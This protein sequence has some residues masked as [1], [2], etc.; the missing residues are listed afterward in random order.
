MLLRELKLY[1]PAFVVLLAPQIGYAKDIIFIEGLSQRTAEK[2]IKM[3]IEEFEA[4]APASQI[5]TTTPWHRQSTFSGISGKDLV[6]HLGIKG[7][8]I[9]ALAIN[10]YQ[11]TIPVSDLTELG[12]LFATRL[13]GK[14]L[15]LRNKGPVFVIYPF[16]QNPSLKTEVYYGRSIWQVKQLTIQ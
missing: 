2:P 13:N 7:T 3:S 11:V 16:D 14:R 10:D 15:K 8:T 4:L 12:V 6:K 5:K 1:I 9:N